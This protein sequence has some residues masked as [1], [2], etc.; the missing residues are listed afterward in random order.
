MKRTSR[1]Y[2]WLGAGA[3]TVG[4]GAALT[5]GCAVASADTGRPDGTSQPTSASTASPSASKNGT[6]A[7][8]KRPQNT[9][10]SSAVRTSAKRTSTG[11]AP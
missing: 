9:A 11:A 4:I 3:V 7:A 5:A 6:G 8:R 1:P 10:V 2:T